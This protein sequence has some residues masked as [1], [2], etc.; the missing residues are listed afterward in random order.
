[1]RTIKL[2]VGIM[3]VSV[4]AAC[5]K[6]VEVPVE[7]PVEVEVIKEIEVEV[8]KEVYINESFYHEM[9]FEGSGYTPSYTYYLSGS[10]LDDVIT[11]LRIDMVSQFGVSKRS[12][13]YLMNNLKVQIG[14]TLKNQ[15]I[16]LFVG[17]SSENIPQI[18]NNIKGESITPEMLVLDLVVQGAYPGA[19]VMFVEEIW[20]VIANGVG[21][22]INE[23]TT[24]ME[25]TEAIG[26]Y[27]VDRAVIKNG[28]K[29]IGLT[30]KWGGNSYNN[31]LTALEDYIVSHEMTLEEA[32]ELVSTTNQ[33]EDRDVVAGATVFFDPKIQSIF[34]LAAGVVDEVS[35]EE[36][37]NESGESVITVE[38]TGLNSMTVEVTV[39][40]GVIVSMVVVAHTETESIG[41]TLIESGEFAGLIIDEQTD[42]DSVDVVAG[43][44]YTSNAL[45][46]AARVALETYNN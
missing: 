34:K 21:I 9:E 7:I 32:Y 33:A 13:D 27:D 23:E 8:I 3:A 22:T 1:M 11:D 43:A 40:D 20:G 19:P 31:Q 28:Y 39:L 10:L 46:E 25:F 15:T 45:I 5:T 44:T 18:F 29:S 2:M 35:V 16:D 38:V 14:G 17:G 42:L 24:L 37:V 36:E 41:G 4:L 26:L 30:G 12:S 6:E